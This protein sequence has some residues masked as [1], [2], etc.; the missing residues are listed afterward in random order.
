MNKLLQLT[1][2]G[3]MAVCGW[4][5]AT[6]AQ[7][8]AAAAP[9]RPTEIYTCNYVDGKGPA[10]LD[11]VVTGWNSWM[12]QDK[13]ESYSAWT[14][15]PEFY[16]PGITFD[17]AWLGGW[18]DGATM[19]T[20]LDRWQR[21]GGKHAKA[22]TSVMECD[23]HASFA[24]MQ[25]KAPSGSFPGD[26]LASFYDCKIKEGQTLD[27][28]IEAYRKWASYAS[29]KGLN[30]AMWLYFPMWAGGKVEYDYKAVYG[31][32]DHK[33]MGADFDDYVNKGGYEKAAEIF[34]GV[35]TC[36][37]AR[38]YTAKLQ[39]NGMPKAP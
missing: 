33:A 9:I 16:G 12:D 5:S 35:E 21:D 38:L 1:I 13:T 4:S 18:P 32:P 19:G 22:F 39:R 7:D 37:S 30:V 6:L 36:D 23:S 15:S 2:V 25:I 27:T 3:S 8:A 28:V 17:V 34:G 26:G 29:S 11:R 31:Y 10:D 24:A 14:M 20:G